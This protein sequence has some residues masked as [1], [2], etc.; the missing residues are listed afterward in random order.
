MNKNLPSFGSPSFFCSASMSPRSLLVLWCLVK[1]AK[2]FLCVFCHVINKFSLFVFIELCGNF[3]Q[4]L[5][6]VSVIYQFSLSAHLC[7]APTLLRFSLLFHP[8]YSYLNSIL[9]FTLWI[10]LVFL[11]YPCPY[12]DI[13][14]VWLFSYL[15]YY[16]TS[17]LC[18]RL[19][20]SVLSLNFYLTN[21]KVLLR[22]EFVN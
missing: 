18:F 22:L 5:Y 14:T 12:S 16:D 6:R 21:C 8:F 3:L 7:H 4:L 20:Y 19:S 13:R 9:Q 17:L 10:I 15:R 2:L 1:E 11:S